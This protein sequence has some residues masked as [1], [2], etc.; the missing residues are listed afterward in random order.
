MQRIWFDI[1]GVLRDFDTAVF[2]KPSPDWDNPPKPVMDTVNNNLQ[3]LVT[4]KE[5]RYVE[6]IRTVTNKIH[7]L[8]AQPK[9]WRPYTEEWLSELVGLDVHAIFVRTQEEKE[10]EL[11]C[12]DILF[13]DY[14]KFSAK[15][16]STR[17]VIIVDA[18]YNRH[19][20]GERVTTPAQLAMLLE[21]MKRRGYEF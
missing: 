14:P 12:G 8:S 17:N 7:V 9:L 15:F 2:G 20:N 18:L 6:A 19:V 11:A 10:L 21:D 5:T 16:M 3:L 4:A 1:D 13:D